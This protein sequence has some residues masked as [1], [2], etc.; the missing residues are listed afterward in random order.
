M[1]KIC[2]I[3]PAYNE[4]ESLPPLLERIDAFY[5][6]TNIPM[7]VL[8]VNDGSKDQTA[9]VVKDFKGSVTVE[10]LDFEKNGGLG[11]VV[12]DG[13]VKRASE[14]RGDDLLVTLDADD[15]QNPFLA[16]AM[17]HKIRQGSQVVIASR[18]RDGSSIKG[19]TLMRKLTS[20][21]AGMLF[22]LTVNLDG[23]KDYTCG[24]RAYRA[25]LIQEAITYYGKDKF[26]EE[27]GFS[28]MIEILLKLNRFNPVFT[29]V[30]MILRY[31][32][33][34]GDSKMNVQRTIKQTLAILWSY[35]STNRFK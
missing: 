24:F 32:L 19:L 17:L 27:R 20:W 35:L 28:C 31:D 33:K 23:V 12:R 18:Y 25:D 16:E 2:F 14:S 30:P 15:S 22:R 7:D 29:E 34:Q 21:A 26:V 3:L 10:L 6:E 9:Q 11:K 1:R 5:T 4:E 8:V 13:L